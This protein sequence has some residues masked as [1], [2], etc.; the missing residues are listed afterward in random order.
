MAIL[1]RESADESF[2][3][4]VLTRW[5]FPLAVRCGFCDHRT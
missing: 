4:I 1:V 2:Q 5:R 3:I